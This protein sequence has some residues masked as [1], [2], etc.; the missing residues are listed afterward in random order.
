VRSALDDARREIERLDL[1]LGPEGK[2]V[3]DAAHAATAEGAGIGVLGL[4]HPSELRGLLA[5]A[6]RPGPYTREARGE[7][8]KE[9][10]SFTGARLHLAPLSNR[11]VRRSGC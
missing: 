1:R 10:L 8:T 2:T 9:A 4:D 11:R 3:V 5:S 6:N 7:F